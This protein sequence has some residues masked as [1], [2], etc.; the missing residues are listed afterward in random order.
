[1][2]GKPELGREH[3]E[4]AIAISGGRHLL[5]KVMYAEN[6]ARLVFDRELHDRLVD[7]VLTANPR[8]KGL[9]LINIVAQGRARLLME[10]A[11]EYF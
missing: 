11:D 5:T 8:A 6:Y 1:M 2:G 4:K 3:F 10:S 7:E 9:T